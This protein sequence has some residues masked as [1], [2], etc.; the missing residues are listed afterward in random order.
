MQ[1]AYTL[2]VLTDIGSRDFHKAIRIC[3]NFATLKQKKL[4]RLYWAEITQISLPHKFNGINF[5]HNIIL[6]IKEPPS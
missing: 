6:I 3:L 5:V 2:G 1:H 4:E